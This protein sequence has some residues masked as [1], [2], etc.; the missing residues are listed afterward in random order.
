MVNLARTFTI[1]VTRTVKQESLTTLPN[2]MVDTS[3]QTSNFSSTSFPLK[4]LSQKGALFR[5]CSCPFL[6]NE[7]RPKE[8]KFADSRQVF[9]VE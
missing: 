8:N 7:N 5:S 9:P 4:D 3:I 1:Y 2:Y 6:N